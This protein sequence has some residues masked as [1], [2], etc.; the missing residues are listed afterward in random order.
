MTEMY[1]DPPPAVVKKRVEAELNDIIG[2]G[3]DVIYIA[4]G[5]LVAKSSEAGYLVGSRGSVG[6]SI[7]A[8][9][10][11][12]TEV[13]AFPA[14]Y[15]CE[16]CR[17]SDFESGAEYGC[18]ADMPDKNC[19]VCGEALLKDGFG[20]PFETFLGFGG[21]KVPDIDLNFSGEYQTRA[22][23]HAEELFGRDKVFRAGTV[24]TM[25]EKT[26]FINVNP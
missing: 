15:R 14:H 4:A 5:R 3:Y 26:A 1:G 23:K 20:I 25:A 2:C 13:N 7:I 19:P 6:S 17:Y 21:D 12:I 8:F 10:S 18:G 9:L 22:H 16:K 24:G 11:G